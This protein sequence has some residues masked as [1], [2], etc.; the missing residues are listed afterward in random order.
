MMKRTILL[1]CVVCALIVIGFIVEWFVG[2]DRP[3]LNVGR[4]TLGGFAAG[5]LTISFWKISSKTSYH[6]APWWLA[7]L[8]I[9]AGVALLGVSWEIFEY[10]L[11][12]VQ[13]RTD[14]GDPYVDTMG[15]L[16]MDLLGAAVSSLFFI[17]KKKEVLPCP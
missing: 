5:W 9:F 15:D 2:G 12:L 6:A 16:K 1:G 11:G 13:H 4:H 10:Q 17:Q 14:I 3:W 8:A 7:I